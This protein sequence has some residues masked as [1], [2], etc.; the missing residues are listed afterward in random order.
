MITEKR[1]KVDMAHLG[2][3]VCFGLFWFFDPTSF[4]SSPYFGMV[5][6]GLCLFFFSFDSF[7]I[8]LAITSKKERRKKVGRW[9]EG[10]QGKKT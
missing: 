6:F 7:I 2:G 10:Q 1:T 8:R 5:A 9:E 3:L 4:L